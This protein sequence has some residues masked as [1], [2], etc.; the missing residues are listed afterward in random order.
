MKKSILLNKQTEPSIVFLISSLS[1][2]GAEKMIAALVNGYSLRGVHVTLVTLDDPK[3]NPDVYQVNKNIKRLVMP[4]DYSENIFL[5][6]SA[7]AKRYFRLRQLL[8]SEMP[9]V[10]LS[11]MTPSNI[12]AIM[13]TRGLPIRCV[14][15]ERI[16]PAF[17]SYGRLFNIAR[18]F[19]YRKA[20]C[21]IAQ[22]S[23]I[24]HW[25]KKNTAS[26]VLI[27]PNFLIK[28]N[29]HL[30]MQKTKVILAV[31]RLD[32]QKGFDVLI[33]AF[34]K[35]NQDFPGWTILIVGQG[36]EH[37]ALNEMI[38]K[39]NL[40]MQIKLCGYVE[41]P[42]KTFQNASIV[43]QPSRFE[44]FPN[45]LL[46][47]MACGFPSIATHE[48][49]EMLIKDGVNGLL[50]PSDDVHALTKALQR[51]IENPQLC[52]MLGKAATGVREAFSEDRVMKLW[53]K[54]LFPSLRIESFG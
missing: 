13:A 20:S 37:D 7:H 50:I 29:Y 22:T 36:P 39:L 31:G 9:N 42:F 30:V 34:A 10:V 12:L 43:V 23:Q 46:E 1:G 15:S 5:K 45:A 18:Y 4:L 24:S 28:D 32:R 35:F 3:K 33:S 16:N 44:G 54:V 25:L 19:F 26:S 51:L 8:Y 41:H 21:V 52:E 2:G 27:I 40:Q 53:D 6:L 38:Y 47:A 11:F 48:A 17:Y 14:V 49:G